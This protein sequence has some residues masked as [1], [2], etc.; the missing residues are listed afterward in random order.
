[1]LAMSSVAWGTAQA[2]PMQDFQRALQRLDR[3][4]CAKL[5]G[6]KCRKAATRPAARQGDAKKAAARPSSATSTEGREGAPAESS[7]PIPKLKPELKKVA[8]T[9]PDDDVVLPRLKPDTLASASS[10]EIDVPRKSDR[11][12][13]DPQRQDVA[14]IKPERKRKSVVD[15][16]ALANPMPDG[17]LSGDACIA[18]LRNMNVNFSQAVTPVSS[19]PC[20][21]YEPIRLNG[22]KVG[23]NAITFPDKP[24]LTCGFAARFAYWVAQEGA[25]AVRKAKGAALQSVGTGPGYQCRGRNGDM[26]AKLS[27][28]AYGN[29]VDIE[30]IKTAEGEIVQVQ[31]ASATT[32]SNA[33][34][35]K[36]LRSEGCRYFTTVLGPGTNSAH[37]RHF[38]FDLERRG[39]KGSHKLCE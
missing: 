28:H 33:R 29:A 1:M 9:A 36:E 34:L 14:I 3:Q 21:V 2:T 26:S 31:A 25:P 37:A 19:G 20:S 30:Y 8:S 38:H 6:A 24:L 17:T 39:K 15:P 23:G 18:A 13:Q 12:V 16:G 35:L 27:E 22:M 4:L 11:R 7:P 10:V 5:P 32:A